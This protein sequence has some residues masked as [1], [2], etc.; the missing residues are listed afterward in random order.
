MRIAHPMLLALV[1]AVCCA[2]EGAAQRLPDRL[3]PIRPPAA[4]SVR[5]Y[6]PSYWVEGATISAAVL[7]ATT[8]FAARGLCGLDETGSPCGFG[9]Y[10]ASAAIGGVVGAALGAIVGGMFDAPHARPLRG[11]PGRAALIGAV[12]G[13][14]WSVGFLC[15]GIE[16]GCG[17]EEPI[18][19]ISVSLAGALAGWLVGR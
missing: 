6:A 19:G 2:S 17:R 15:H 9:T 12:G 1:A 13:A 3:Q 8:V 11:H 16:D 18:F 7:G 4:D 10:A 14:L 5:V